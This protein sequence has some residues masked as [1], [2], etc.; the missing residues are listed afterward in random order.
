MGGLC[1]QP[2][3]GFLDPVS[4]CV[5][6]HTVLKLIAR[7]TCYLRAIIYK[8]RCSA[9]GVR[10][11][12]Y[13]CDPSHARCRNNYMCRAVSIQNAAPSPPLF[14]GR[15]DVL[16]LTR[17]L[18]AG[19][20]PRRH[21]FISGSVRVGCAVV[22]VAL[23]QFSTVSIIPLVLHIHSFVVLPTVYYLGN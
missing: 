19:L 9:L 21:D 20:S 23:L 1:H 4:F 12:R 3:F 7:F 5:V 13:R 17:P 16:T 2:K 18:V 8:F 15:F 10:N 22:R 6:S 11:N 14:F